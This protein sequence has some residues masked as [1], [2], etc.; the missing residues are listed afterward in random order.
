MCGIAGVL[1]QRL[2]APEGGL[3]AMR[4]ALAHRGPDACGLWSDPTVGVGL[5]HRR[6]SI[7]DL[8]ENGAQPMHSASGRFVTTYNGEIYNFADLRR[9]LELAGHR[10]RGHCDTE[11][12]LAA[13]EQW[14]VHA[15]LERCEG[16]FAF[17]LWDRQ[18]AR[19]HLARD[20]MG[21]KPLYY[22]WTPEG[23][24]FASELKALR[25]C[26]GFRAELD[27]EAL[28]LYLEYQYIP[29]PFSVYRN[30]R[31]LPP[32]CI[33]SVTPGAACEPPCPIPYWSLKQVA[34]RGLCAPLE[35]DET[36]AVD[37]LERLL[38]RSIG[39]RMVADVPVGA[40][41][42]GGIDS[43]TVVALAQAE[44]SLPVRT[45]SIGFAER[46]YD[47]AVSA[48]AVAAHLKTDHTELYVT[49]GEAMA[50]I[51]LMPDLYDEPFADN[52]QIPTYL[53]AKLARQS[54]KVSIS[55]DG[56][57]ELFGG[58]NRHWQG[59]RAWAARRWLPPGIRGFVAAAADTLSRMPATPARNLS[60]LAVLMRARST[61]TV[62]KDLVADQKPPG[63]L[64]R[65]GS[66]S[67][68][69]LWEIPPLGEIA[70]FAHSIMYS[71]AIAYL[72]GDILVKV[73][74]ATMGVS[75]EARTPYLDAGVVEFAWQ[76]PLSLKIRPPW[77]KYILR[78]VLYR[79][80][81]R[82]L[83][84]RPKQGFSVPIGEW[85]RGPMREWAEDLLSESRLEQ[86]GVLNPN[87]VRAMWRQHLS[88][89]REWRNELWSVL[90]LQAWRA[91]W[92][93]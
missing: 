74:R 76:L 13:C 20:R 2:L 49:P 87:T 26:P 5:G 80:V 43:S 19:L 40:F 71:D 67:V 69:D 24:I 36:E 56:G 45:F 42:S 21:E 89:A 51:P 27:R 48:K 14:G 52:S 82:E 77:S 63:P 41:L 50:T 33:L 58:Y 55:G 75:L 34:E 83:I 22:G 31:K 79:H 47:E 30:V 11:V 64:M 4:D 81:P 53:V 15:A 90:M 28:A 70:G 16:M 84:D 38:R 25:A 32:G 92:R 44:S 23:L 91:R 65:D 9:E 72:P 62:Y 57:D 8:S 61:G 18:Q 39:L 29:E 3:A 78:Q 17:A 88:G 6:L 7:L 86:G 59:S 1:G 85:L 35:C 10:F 60:K 93:V 46:G 37:E 73:D 68:R 54:V 66:R 12:L